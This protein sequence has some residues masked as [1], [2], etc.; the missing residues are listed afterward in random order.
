MKTCPS[1]KQLLPLE[2]FYS[3]QSKKSGHSCYCKKCDRARI[4]AAYLLNPENHRRSA[5]KR[6]EKNPEKA[7]QACRKWR[8]NNRKASRGSA[9][10]QRLK[11]YYGI[12]LE[13]YRAMLTSQKGVCSICGGVNPNGYRLCIDHCHATGKIRGLLCSLCNTALG[14]LKDSPL[15]FRKAADYLENAQ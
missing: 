5:K 7:R 15:L 12:S 9:R 4:N 6:R 1:C 8:K 11:R 3:N 14:Y 13:Q 10:E 2:D